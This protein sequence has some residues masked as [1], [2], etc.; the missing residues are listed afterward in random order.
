M[1]KVIFTIVFRDDIPWDQQEADWKKHAEIVTALP[2]VVKY[3]QNYKIAEFGSD[4]GL[5]APKAWDGIAELYF[6]DKA[7]YDAVMGS[8][9]WE[10]VMEDSLKFA[11]L[12]STGA[13]IVQEKQLL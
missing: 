5:D 13:G 7:A 2:G 3:V 12:E 9:A 4:D 10:A 8:P 11:N 1:H 6:A